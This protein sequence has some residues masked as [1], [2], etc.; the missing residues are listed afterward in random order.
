MIQV[1]WD[2]HTDSIIDVKLGN[3]DADSY[4]FEP[5]VVLLAQ[6]EKINKDKQGKNW[7][8]KQKQIYLFISSVD[9]M[10][11]REDLFSPGKFESTH[12]S[13]NRLAHF[14][15]E[16]MDKTSDHNCSHEIVFTHD[17]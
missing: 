4:I 15:R 12:V 6:W 14:T 16:K 11:G 17:P 8:Y 13:K 2:R 7:H 1:L 10:L 9:G 3:A 5:M